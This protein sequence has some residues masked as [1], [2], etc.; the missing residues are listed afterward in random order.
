MVVEQEGQMEPDLLTIKP[1]RSILGAYSL[2][3]HD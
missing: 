3:L 1:C 2:V